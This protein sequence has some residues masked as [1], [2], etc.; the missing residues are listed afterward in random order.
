MR[1]G[2]TD[3]HHTV[4]SLIKLRCPLLSIAA[5]KRLSSIVKRFEDLPATKRRKGTSEGLGF[6]NDNLS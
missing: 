2:K 1:N 6:Q 4:S 5:A 3:R